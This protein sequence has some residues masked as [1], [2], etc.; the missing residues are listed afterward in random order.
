MLRQRVLTA[1]VLAV[2]AV[3]GVYGLP[4]AVFSAVVAVLVLLA[5]WEWS[6]LT[7]LFRPVAR[8]AYVLV[9][10][11]A[12]AGLS[13]AGAGAVFAVLV[14]ALLWWLAAFVWVL[15]FPAGSGLWQAGWLPPA[16]A[17]LLVMVPTWAAI[18]TVHRAFGPSYLLTVFLL[19]WGAD[20][21]AYFA[22]RRW[23]RHKLAPQVSPGKTWQ[24]FAGALAVAAVVTGVATW[25]FQASPWFPLVCFA[26]VLASVLGDL[27]ESMFKRLADVKDS[28]QLL[29][30]H[31][32]I[33]DRVDSV[34]AAA[35]VYAAGLLVI[36]GGA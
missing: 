27:V 9:V 3:W 16:V 23:G 33:L 22:G 10:A 25:Y 24:G 30:G 13:G 8:A 15:R 4:P 29:P 20:I 2:L 34:T 17:G 28:S 6:R 1:L 19:V 11:A 14:A 31:G 36:G 5:A 18:A 32:G 12:I 26:A 7:H 35:P 21:G